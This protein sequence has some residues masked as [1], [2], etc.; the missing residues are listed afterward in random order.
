[1]TDTWTLTGGEIE[2][3]LRDGVKEDKEFIVIVYIED[4]IWVYSMNCRRG[5][6]RRWFQADL[7]LDIDD[8]HPTRYFAIGEV[9]PN[10][11]LLVGGNDEGL[12]ELVPE[13]YAYPEREPM[14]PLN[15]Q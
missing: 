9:G 11:N 3:L 4:E 12:K 1:M 6:L 13:I 7:G 10:G 14:F 2:D 8:L 5:D 15:L